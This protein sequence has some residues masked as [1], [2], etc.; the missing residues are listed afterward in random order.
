LR[1]FYGAAA[2]FPYCNL[3]VHCDQ[4]LVLDF[5]GEEG[6]KTL[7]QW[8]KAHSFDIHGTPP[9]AATGGGGRHVYYRLPADRMGEGWGN[10]VRAAPGVDIRTSGGYVVM[11]PSIH[12]SKRRYKWVRG[13]L[14]V[15]VAS[16]PFCPDWVFTAIEEE[17]A[18]A[19]QKGDNGRVP[20][21][22]NRRR[23]VGTVDFTK[24]TVTAKGGRNHAAAKMAGRL[25]SE[26]FD[27]WEVEALLTKFNNDFLSPSLTCGELQGV[28][29]SVK[30]YHR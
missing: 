10:M 22:I 7:R 24:C 8:A 12:A 28:I 29:E 11:P 19:R 20:I 5:D 14:P 13:R 18:K 25:F 23:P 4:L 9:V 3:G 30:R 1:W 2:A 17:R 15:D 27:L 16:M 26:G 21:D 6:M